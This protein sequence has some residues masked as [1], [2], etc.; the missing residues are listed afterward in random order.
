MCYIYS[1]KITNK[2]ILYYGIKA[3]PRTVLYDQKTKANLVQWPVEEV[4]TLR[5]N[6]KEFDKV[7]VPAG[8]VLH[9]DVSS[10]TEV[11][12]PTFNPFS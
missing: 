5:K 3:L 11:H 4:E 8:S 7:E 10:A 6:V 9:L 12:M 2:F 1:N